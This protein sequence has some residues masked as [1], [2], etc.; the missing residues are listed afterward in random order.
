METQ[1]GLRPNT[2]RYRAEALLVGISIVNGGT[3]GVA[4]I[5]IES[6]HVERKAA[7][8][9]A[10]KAVRE[11]LRSWTIRHLQASS[12]RNQA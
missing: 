12:G 9:A 6:G 5:D 1:L 7:R 8:K 2:S 11:L 10:R 4:T 3:I